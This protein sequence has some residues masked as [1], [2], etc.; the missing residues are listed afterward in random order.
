MGYS[1]QAS[2]SAQIEERK[3]MKEERTEPSQAGRFVSANGIRLYYLDHSGEGPPLLLLPGLTANAHSFDGLIEAGLS[4]WF[5]VLALD[6]RG[7]GKSDKPDS[8]YSMA[9]HAADVVALMDA[10]ELRSAIIGGHSF[11]GLLTIYLAANYPDYVSRLV[12]LDAS[13]GLVNPTVRELIKPSLERL[14]KEVPSWDEYIGAMKRAPFYEGWW[15]PAIESYYRADVI[16]NDDGSVRAR[17][18]PENIIEAIDRVE[19]EDWPR[20][21]AA[22]RQPAILIHAPEPF[23]PT[24]FPSVVS[25]QDA[26][27]TVNSF[28]NCRY[29]KVPGNHMTML[30]GQGA[31]RMVSLIREFAERE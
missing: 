2:I 3:V 21:V 12:I 19:D 18:R 6:L 15:D 7:R 30:F 11:G 14:G 26:D 28:A 9:E 27:F 16:F 22:I 5:R 20:H 31:S 23:G 1:A 13:V 17:S 8:G 25:Q 24:D 4:R 29:E 10:L